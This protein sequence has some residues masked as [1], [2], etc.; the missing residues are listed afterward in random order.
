MARG[1]PVTA[2]IVWCAK[3]RAALEHLAG[4]PDFGQAGVVARGLRSSTRVFG[5][6]A[7]LRRVGFVLLR[8]PVGRPLPDVADHVVDAVAIGREGDDG[9]SALEPVLLEVLARKLALP[10]IGH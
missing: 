5:D 7:S 1:G 3:M 10:G 8:I 2:A 4:N 9:R 6:A